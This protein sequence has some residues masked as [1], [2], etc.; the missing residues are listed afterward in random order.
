[1]MYVAVSKGLYA[2]VEKSISPCY[3]IR[4]IFVIIFC[5]ID[6]N[7]KINSRFTS[8]QLTITVLRFLPLQLHVRI[9][10][11]RPIVRKKLTLEQLVKNDVQCLKPDYIAE[12]LSKGEVEVEAF[13]INE[14]K[15]LLEKQR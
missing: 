14:V 4:A 15:P 11:V 6:T 1:M 8:S 10:N 2:P 5:T 13:Y 9:H 3:E 7:R 12:Y